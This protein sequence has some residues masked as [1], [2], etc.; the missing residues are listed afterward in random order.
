[1]HDYEVLGDSYQ[2]NFQWFNQA[3]SETGFWFCSELVDNS[4]QCPEFTIIFIR[5]WEILI[6]YQIFLSPQMRDYYV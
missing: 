3:E 6:F 5:F 2:M 1:M 4:L